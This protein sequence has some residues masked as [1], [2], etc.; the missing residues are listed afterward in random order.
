M[1]LEL[2]IDKIT[3]VVDEMLTRLMKIN[4]IEPEYNEDTGTSSYDVGKVKKG[5]FTFSDFYTLMQVE[6]IK[7]TEMDFHVEVDKSVLDLDVPTC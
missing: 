2:S 5:I 6:G 7:I 3:G 1:K 4:N